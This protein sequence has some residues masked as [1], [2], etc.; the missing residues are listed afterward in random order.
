MWWSG[1]G[2]CCWCMIE[3]AA[4]VDSELKSKN[5]TCPIN[6]PLFYRLDLCF[7]GHATAPPRT[8]GKHRLRAS[9]LVGIAIRP[10]SRVLA[11]LAGEQKVRTRN[12]NQMRSPGCDGQTQS[13]HLRDDVAGL[14][15]KVTQVGVGIVEIVFI[16]MSKQ[17]MEEWAA[18][19][20]QNTGELW[21]PIPFQVA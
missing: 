12:C 18:A 11:E 10:Q 19:G 2:L 14:K 16:D 17:T 7:V 1:A 5:S 6:Q 15:A 3:L 8:N 21:D 13:S 20:F 4:G 9:Q